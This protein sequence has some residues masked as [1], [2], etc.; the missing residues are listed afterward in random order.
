M[1]AP[2]KKVCFLTG[3]SGRLGS[4]L[5]ALL[6]R[7]GY[8]IFFTYNKS[9][10]TAAKVLQDLRAVSPESSMTRCDTSRVSDIEDAFRLFSE[11]YT[12]LDLLIASASSFFSTPLP[13][14]TEKQWEELVGTNLKGTFFTMQTGARIMKE[15]PFVSHIVT[16]SDIAADLVWKGF[17]PYSASKAAVQHLTRVFA[18]V[19][20]PKILV[21]S[22]APGTVTKLPEWN[23]IPEE[24]LAADISLRRIGQPE[25]IV[26]ALLFFVNS[27][28]ITGQIINVEGGRLL[29]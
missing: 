18:K 26:K 3:G 25:D 20:A 1:A 7:E 11:R 28:Y 23:D 15:Q 8:T 27:D 9:T 17:A 10:D 5:A 4:E 19:F 12:R 2:D 14:V 29:N 13:D 6:A 21:N 22:I 24:E 16:I